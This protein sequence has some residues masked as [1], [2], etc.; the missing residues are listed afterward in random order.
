MNQER[1]SR[2]EGGASAVEYSL[3]VAAIAAVIIALVFSLGKLTEGN[4]KTTC[5]EMD[6]QMSVSATC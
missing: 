1:K 3:I 4:F 6:S 5:D 2:A